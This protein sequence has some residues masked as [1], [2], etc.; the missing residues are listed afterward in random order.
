MKMCPSQLLPVISGGQ[1]LESTN[2]HGHGHMLEA[3]VESNSSQQTKA[4]SLS[5]S[6]SRLDVSNFSKE[7]VHQLL[8]VV[9]DENIAIPDSEKEKVRTLDFTN[10][11]VW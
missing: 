11:H 9:E 4:R 6:S 5:S 8:T 10:Y 3:I 1:N 2:V 7:D